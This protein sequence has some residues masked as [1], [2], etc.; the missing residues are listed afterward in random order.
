M[1]RGGPRSVT[2]VVR[3]GAL[4][5]LQSEARRRQALA[6]EVRSALP[7]EEA[8]HVVGAEL[9]VE[10]RLVIAVD[11]AAWAARLRFA[12]IGGRAVRVRVT[13]VGDS[14]S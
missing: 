10:G 11:S 1:K 8:R 5:G 3:T 14:R 7:A 13:P 6:A 9:D 2:E 4:S 12:E